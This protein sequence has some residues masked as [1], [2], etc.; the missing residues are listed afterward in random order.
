MRAFRPGTSL[1]PAPTRA[2]LKDI[3]SRIEDVHQRGYA[4]EPNVARIACGTIRTTGGGQVSPLMETVAYLH[5]A[6]P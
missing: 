2:V 6:L 3:S 1:E 4:R 5:P